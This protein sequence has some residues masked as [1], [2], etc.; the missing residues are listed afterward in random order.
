MRLFKRKDST[1]IAQK[2]CKYDI[3]PNWTPQISL[4]RIERKQF[5]NVSTIQILPYLILWGRV[6]NISAN[7][8][9]KFIRPSS[10]LITIEITR[11]PFSCSDRMQNFSKSTRSTSRIW[12]SVV[13]DLSKFW[14]V[15]ADAR[16]GGTTDKTL[17]ESPWEAILGP[18]A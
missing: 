16:G 4:N 14:L 3:N 5:E 7:T 8:C 10:P 6:A 11:S 12:K 1:E 13:I 18:A 9:R 2:K 17:R 15:S